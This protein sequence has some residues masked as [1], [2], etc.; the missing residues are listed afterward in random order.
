MIRVLLL[1]FAMLLPVQARAVVTWDDLHGLVLAGQ[2]APVESSLQAALQFDMAVR[3]ES[4]EQRKL[5][6]LFTNSDPAI[7][8][9]LARWSEERPE[10][11]LAMTAMGWHLWKRGWN[12]RGTGQGGQVYQDAMRSF[13]E[14]HAAALELAQQAIAADPDLVAASDLVLRLA[15]SV[16]E[17]GTAQ[18][19]LE[20]IMALHPNRGSL[21]RAMKSLAPQWGGSPAQVK[22]LCERFAPMVVTVKGYDQTVCAID[23]VYAGGFW[24]GAQ[25]DEAHQLLMLTP[26]PVLDY[27]RLQDV[28]AGFGNATSRIKTLEKIKAERALTLEEASALDQARAELAGGLVLQEEWKIALATA[29]PALRREADIDPDSPGTVETY[30]RIRIDA[31]RNLGVE[32]EADDLILR[33]QRLLTVVPYAAESWKLLGDLTQWDT[34]LVEVDL[35]LMERVEP[36]YIN[37]VVYSNYDPDMVA[38][39]VE[40]KYWSIIDPTNILQSRDISGLGPEERQRL[41]KVVHC[42][43]LRQMTILN[44]VCANHGIGLEQCGGFPA[45]PEPILTQLRDVVAG[46][47]CTFEAELNRDPA[48]LLYTP[49]SIIF[50]PAP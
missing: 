18:I 8:D 6:T 21:V 3:G 12:A 17:V 2:V 46:G 7:A 30:V 27:A 40:A 32:L 35:A 5:F 34:P 16:G 14:D 15:A 4:D 38:A 47:A 19:E 13:L 48:A 41:D 36:Y 44:I 23:A 37:A 33:L 1:A 10:S 39:L 31:A 11:A 26:N 9:F 22:H 45:S 24:D 25:R 49:I 20:R 50:P 43:M 29:L 42:P 28:M